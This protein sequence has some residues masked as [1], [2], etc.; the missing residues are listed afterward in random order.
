M[1]LGDVVL[2]VI[3]GGLA[4]VLADIVV[5]GIR[6]DLVSAIVVGILGGLLGGWLFRTVGFWPG[7]GFVGSLVTAFVGAIV[8][9]LILRAVR[10]R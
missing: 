6:L 5:K 10:R 1:D 7:G 2:W 8:L 3:V 9:L 4:G